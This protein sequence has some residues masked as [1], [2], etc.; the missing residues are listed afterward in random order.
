MERG[1]RRMARRRA[2]GSDRA[3]ALDTVS[4]EAASTSQF[5]RVVIV[6]ELSPALAALERIWEAKFGE[7]PGTAWT[8]DTLDEIAD[9]LREAGLGPEAT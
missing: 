5:A 4:L 3:D 7:G 2:I 8:P 6:A 1:V 9:A